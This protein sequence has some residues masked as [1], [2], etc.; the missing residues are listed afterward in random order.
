[1]DTLFGKKVIS[2]ISFSQAEIL[3]DIVKLY[4]PGGIECDCTYG[5]GNFY[6][7]I[8]QPKYKFDLNPISTDIVK[9][10]SEQLPLLEA[11]IKSMMYDPPFISS[12]SVDS[13]PYKMT[14]R[15]TNVRGVGKLKALYSN[16][17]IEFNRVM[18]RRG[19][20]VFKCQDTVCGVKNE[21]LHLYVCNE[22]EKYGFA[23][24]D[25]FVLLSK[26]RFIGAGTQRHA[27]KFHC[28]FWVFKKVKN[29]EAKPII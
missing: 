11:S 15:F 24:V 10:S 2:S 21:F 16:S 8:N 1:M 9:A 3:Q 17:L 14:K 23:A 12:H 20:L 6:S 5:K 13:V 28:Y 26:S 22:A 27:R 25:L 29:Y 19:I 4:V 7:H 18:K